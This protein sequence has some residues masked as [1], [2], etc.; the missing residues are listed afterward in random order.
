MFT[1]ECIRVVLCSKVEKGVTSAISRVFF[2]FWFILRSSTCGVCVQAHVI[3][4]FR[5][6]VFRKSRSYMTFRM[7]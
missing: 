1:T 7:L 6:L 3:V 5:I 4:V 2:F